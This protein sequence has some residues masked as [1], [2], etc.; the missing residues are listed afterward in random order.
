MCFP[1]L[2]RRSDKFNHS[3]IFAAGDLRF[4]QVIAVCFVDDN[5]IRKFHD[6][7]LDALKFITG[8]GENDEHEEVYHI[9][10]C[11]FRLAYANGFDQDY[12]AACR[13][14]EKHGF[15]ALSGYAAQGSARR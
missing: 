10:D 4:R 11:R 8:T 13:F 1:S 9:T 2:C 6:A 3:F 12:I 14:A 7:L 5:S 15:T